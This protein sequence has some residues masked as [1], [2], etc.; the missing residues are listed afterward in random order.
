MIAKMFHKV[1][2]GPKDAYKEISLMRELM[3]VTPSHYGGVLYNA[4]LDGAKS[5]GLE[6]EHKTGTSEDIIKALNEGKKVIVGVDPS[7]YSPSPKGGHAV[8]ISSY[9]DGKFEV[10]NPA[11][12]QPMLLGAKEVD[13]A[14]SAL[15]NNMVIIGNP[16]SSNNV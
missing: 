16:P 2:G 11:Y 13:L 8:A 12:P 14:M 1:G 10:Y 15:G 6:A 5:L 7:K 9:H 4:F 3:G